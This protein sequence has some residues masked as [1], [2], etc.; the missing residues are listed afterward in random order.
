MLAV[1]VLL[2]LTV[3]A[4][5]CTQRQTQSVGLVGFVVQVPLTYRVEYQS[6][7]VGEDTLDAHDERIRITPTVDQTNII[8]RAVYARDFATLA[9]AWLGQRIPALE[10]QQAIVDD[11][12]L[13]DSV[14]PDE[15]E[16]FVNYGGDSPNGDGWTVY[17]GGTWSFEF[18]TADGSTAYT[19]VIRNAVLLRISALKDG[20]RTD[21]HPTVVSVFI[22]KWRLPEGD[23]RI[24]LRCNLDWQLQT[25]QITHRWSYNGVF[26]K[27]CD[28][29]TGLVKNAIDRLADRIDDALA[30]VGDFFIRAVVEPIENITSSLF[31]SSI[32]NAVGIAMN[33]VRLYC[34][35]TIDTTQNLLGLSG[36]SNPGFVGGGGAVTFSIELDL[37]G[38]T[39]GIIVADA[40]KEG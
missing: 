22:P 16:D 3:F 25:Y 26:D 7:D 37:T 19:K 27:I 12:S 13:M 10:N 40:R 5:G 24:T 30:T 18:F 21:L 29:A 34:A 20:S 33:G 31:P 36:Y 35:K 1:V 14:A 23:G 6:V 32:A 28:K 2:S 4:S 8:S 39:T 15:N 38:A 9:R 17:C 11:Y